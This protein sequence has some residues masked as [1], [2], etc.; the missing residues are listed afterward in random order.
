MQA[1]FTERILQAE[2]GPLLTHSLRR[3][4]RSIP[5]AGG[6]TRGLEMLEC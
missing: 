3:P 5:H 4:Q 6:Q 2:M 1:A